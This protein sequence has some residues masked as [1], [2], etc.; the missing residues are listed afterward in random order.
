MTVVRLAQAR[1]LAALEHPRV[2]QVVG[3]V[4]DTLPMAIVFARMEQGNLKAYLRVRLRSAL[5]S[6]V[7]ACAWKREL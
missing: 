5:C 6:S 2:V 7:K 1:L 3:L 4:Q